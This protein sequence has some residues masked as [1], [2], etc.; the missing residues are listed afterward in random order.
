MSA[1]ER[2]RSSIERMPFQPEPGASHGLTVS[3]GV[4]FTDSP[5]MT[6]ELLLQAADHAM[7]QAKRAGRNRVEMAPPG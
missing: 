7:Y 4:S 6:P 3:I 2:L 1:A 5:L